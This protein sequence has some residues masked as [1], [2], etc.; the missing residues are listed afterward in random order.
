[1]ID[2][3]QTYCIEG[4]RERGKGEREGGRKRGWEGEE[5]RPA[6]RVQLGYLQSLCKETCEQ[7]F[8]YMKKNIE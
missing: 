1:M 5:I 2:I 4:S 6:K 8:V 7:G 3:M